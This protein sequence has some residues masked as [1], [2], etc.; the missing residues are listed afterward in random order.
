MDPLSITAAGAGI[1]VPALQSVRF[2]VRTI[3]N[4]IDAPV[5]D[6]RADFGATQPIL[7]NIDNA[8][9]ASPSDLIQSS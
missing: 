7:Q 8:L 3:D 4:I 1:T 2:L 6:I 9:K 5:K